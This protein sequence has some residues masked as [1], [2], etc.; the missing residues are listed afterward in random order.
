MIVS[1]LYEVTRRLLSVPSVLLRSEAAKDAELLVLRHE[2]AILRRQV[3]GPVRYE[4]SDRFRFAALSGPVDRLHRRV[5]LGAQGWRD[6]LDGVGEWDAAV[7]TTAL[8]WVESS[9]LVDLYAELAE[10]IR[11]GGVLVNGDHLYDDQSRGA[12]VDRPRAGGAGAAV[13]CHRQRGVVGV[14]GGRACRSD[15]ERVVPV[16]A[17]VRQ[18]R[19]RQRARPQRHAAM[20]RDAGF[21]EVGVVWQSGDDVVQVAVR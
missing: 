1:L 5:E 9:R 16:R 13:G 19:A 4:P 14:V 7:S 11:P 6:A 21:R 15:V 10:L 20:L 8:H 2:N 18:R 3:T 12:R 17:H